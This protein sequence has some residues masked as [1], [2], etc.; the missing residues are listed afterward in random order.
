MGENNNTNN[1]NNKSNNNSN[2]GSNTNTKNFSKNNNNRRYNGN[3]NNRSKRFNKT[4][5]SFNNNRAKD[6][7]FE[8]RTDDLKGYVFDCDHGGQANQYEKTYKEIVE[9]IGRKYTYGSDIKWTLENMEKMDIEEPDDPPDGDD[10]EVFNVKTKIEIWKRQVAEY[11]K[12]VQALEENIKTAYTLILGQCSDVLK[13][14]LESQNGYEDINNK[15]DAIKLLRLIRNICFNS[16]DQK[17]DVSSLYFAKQFFSDISK[18]K[19][20]AMQSI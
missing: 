12:R 15:Y 18:R 3:S 19:N 9:Y 17:Y 11:V 16:Q 10:E 8:G 13:A 2:T 5:K 20:K 6:T 1:N 4:N 7:K 14:K